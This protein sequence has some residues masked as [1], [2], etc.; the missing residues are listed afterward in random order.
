MTYFNFLECVSVIYSA[1]NKFIIIVDYPLKNTQNR[2]IIVQAVR[3]G[4]NTSSVQ[5]RFNEE[6]CALTMLVRVEMVLRLFL[7]TTTR[8]ITGGTFYV[9]RKYPPLRGRRSFLHSVNVKNQARV[10]KTFKHE[11]GGL[12]IF[13]PSL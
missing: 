9:N 3:A 1:V 7:K 5:K 4:T 10:Q 6:N 2:N 8:K 13:R 12:P 11:S